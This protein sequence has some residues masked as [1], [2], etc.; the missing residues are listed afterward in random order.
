MTRGGRHR[1]RCNRRL[2]GSGRAVGKRGRELRV[3][4]QA[5]VGHVGAGR[6]EACSATELERERRLL[7]SEE[8]L[9]GGGGGGRVAEWKLLEK[10]RRQS[11]GGRHR[12]PVDSRRVRRGARRGS[13]RRRHRREPVGR[14]PGQRLREE[15]SVGAG[16]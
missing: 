15:L 14:E 1:L 5:A 8:L 13:E 16:Q 12:E 2:A 7:R 6:R 10:T 9:E 3:D 11:S 4:A